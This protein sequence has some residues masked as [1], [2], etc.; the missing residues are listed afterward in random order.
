MRDF[1]RFQEPAW[2]DVLKDESLLD[3]FISSYY[4]EI[5]FLKAPS[6]FGEKAEKAIRKRYWED[7]ERMRR[8]GLQAEDIPEPDFP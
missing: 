1:L 5:R 6:M 3:D 4:E 8:E 7:R 2:V